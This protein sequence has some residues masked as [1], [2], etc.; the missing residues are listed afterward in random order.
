MLYP[1]KGDRI[2]TIDSVTSLHPI[3]IGNFITDL[4][5]LSICGRT[6]F[7]I[8]PKEVLQYATSRFP[9]YKLT[10]HYNKSRES[11]DLYIP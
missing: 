6:A 3:C 1:Q 11:V 7:L 5:C 9:V 4:R 8:R 10:V 2:V